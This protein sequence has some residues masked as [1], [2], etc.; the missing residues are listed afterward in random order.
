MPQDEDRQWVEFLS[1]KEDFYWQKFVV[2]QNKFE[3][4]QKGMADD[5]WSCNKSDFKLVNWAKMMNF[6]LEKSSPSFSLK[7]ALN[8]PFLSSHQ[9]SGKFN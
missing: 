4:I 9:S 2:W 7:F 1:A 6:H 3:D 8:L 5:E